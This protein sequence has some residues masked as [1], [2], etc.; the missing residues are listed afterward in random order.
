M[1]TTYT[2]K[3]PEE[4]TVSKKP[5]EKKIEPKPAKHKCWLSN[6]IGV[7]HAKKKSKDLTV[8][9]ITDFSHCVKV[10]LDSQKKQLLPNPYNL[11]LP[12]ADV[13]KVIKWMD[14]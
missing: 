5:V 14:N 2:T 7:L 4:Q 8:L 10:V 3:A 1:S 12:I 13:E 11:S 9:T 6:Q